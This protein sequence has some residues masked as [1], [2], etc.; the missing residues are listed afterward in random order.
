MINPAQNINF[1]Q[2]SSPM[3]SI[4]LELIVPVTLQ[5]L[6]QIL[7]RWM[8]GIE[9]DADQYDVK[10]MPSPD[11]ERL[12]GRLEVTYRQRTLFYGNFYK[13]YLRT[14]EG[15]RTIQGMVTV[16]RRNDGRLLMSPGETLTLNIDDRWRVNYN[17][18]QADLADALQDVL[19]IR[20]GA[21]VRRIAEILKIGPEHIRMDSYQKR[22]VVD[23][24]IPELQW[25]E[26]PSP[27]RFYKYVPLDVFHKMLLNGT[28]R[29]NS[30]ISQSDTEETFY[31]G[32]LLSADYEDE[33][34][35]FAG[36]LS[37]HTV[38]I[39]SFT[40]EYDSQEMWR[41]YAGDGR[42]VCLGF[43]LTGGR[44]LHQMQYVNPQESALL[45]LK[46]Q[47]MQLRKEGI[48]VHFSAVDNRRRFV[49]H[50]KYS[51]EKE[52][53][54][55][56]DDY[57]DVDN[58]LYENGTRCVTF[59]DFQFDGREL[60]EIGLRLDSVLIGPHQP[61]GADNFPLLAQRAHQRF[62]DEIVINRSTVKML[63]I[64]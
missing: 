40:T 51:A 32:N 43:S 59:K 8:E 24:P 29:M 60:P 4:E 25:K 49:K 38:L 47:V 46:E 44:R 37:E 62:G 55:I 18:R 27:E 63:R 17:G 52:W 21:E 33:F 35:R 41:D 20:D 1:A 2:T 15:K 7:R 26:D 5:T 3:P 16:R 9:M 28:F 23:V 56:V 22:Y 34:K 64:I 31:L 19:P 11:A 36:V 12:Y 30:I 58:E 45:K 39:S 42:G 14:E 61:S 10:S 6:E 50:L 57:K 54:M 53:R 13:K 48:R